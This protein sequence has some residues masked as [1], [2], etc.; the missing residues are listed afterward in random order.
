M[1]VFLR[2]KPPLTKKDEESFLFRKNKIELDRKLKLQFAGNSLSEVAAS[3]ERTYSVE[4]KSLESAYSLGEV[5]TKSG[6]NYKIKT[7]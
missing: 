7:K 2:Q 6:E 3:V 4:N 1:A 5:Q